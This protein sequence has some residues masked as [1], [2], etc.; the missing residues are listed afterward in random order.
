MVSFKVHCKL[1]KEILI[2]TLKNFETVFMAT[3]FY[4]VRIAQNEK[5]FDGKKTLQQ[6]IHNFE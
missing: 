5:H 2:G 4:N 3:M 6:V 1:Y